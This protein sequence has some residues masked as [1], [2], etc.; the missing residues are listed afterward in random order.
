MVDHKVTRASRTD[1]RVEHPHPPLKS[2]APA[3]RI[4]PYNAFLRPI[5]CTTRCSSSSTGR[6]ELA[7]LRILLLVLPTTSFGCHHSHPPGQSQ[8]PS[9]EDTGLQ[10]TQDAN[11]SIVALRISDLVLYY[12]GTYST[13]TSTYTLVQLLIPG[14]LPGTTEQSIRVT[15]LLTVLLYVYQVYTALIPVVLCVRWTIFLCCVYSQGREHVRY[16]CSTYLY[17]YA[18][19]MQGA[20][21]YYT[22]ITVV[23]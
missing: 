10:Q 5:Y 22:Y 12:I 15:V 21:I 23:S 16:C 17:S 4:V 1:S 3:G 6:K 7:G 19:V 13:T 2:K 20:C 18:V 9:G 8:H 11:M 14:M